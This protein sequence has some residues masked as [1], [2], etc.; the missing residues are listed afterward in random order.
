MGGQ[1]CI[2]YGAA[3]FTRDSDFAVSPDEANLARLRAALAELDARA[4][5][6]PALD[7]AVLEKGHACHFRCGA[8]EV[9]D[10]RIDVMSKLRGC[11]EF[12]QLWRRRTRVRLS[13][14]GTV[15]AL[16]IE[17][18]VVAKKTQRDKD[19]PMIARL[20]EADYVRC[21]MRPPPSRVQ[22]WLREART[23]ELLLRLVKRFPGT[24]RRLAATRPALAAALRGERRAIERELHREQ[25]R[26]RAAD[27]AYWA[28][29]RAELAQWRRAGRVSRVPHT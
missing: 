21:G 7:P 28:A 17:D 26:E 16:G 13:P 11:P 2:L 19:W 10:W 12:A 29:L 4:I 25:E 14:R 6:V 15:A 8:P 3:E 24:S 9:R 27:R 1:A 20:V 23:A 5:Y 22:F 18:L